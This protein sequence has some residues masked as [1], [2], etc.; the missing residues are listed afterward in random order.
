MTTRRFSIKADEYEV[1]RFSIPRRMDV[2][3]RLLAASPVNLVL[4]DA[5]DKKKYEDNARQT[6]EYE[7]SWGRRSDL[8]ASVKLDA[9]TWYLIIEGSTD[10]S[11]GILEIYLMD[12]V[13]SSS[14]VLL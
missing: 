12:D 5:E 7:A 3:I 4:L 14:R 6:H 1:F 2:H 9:G 13:R 11:N 8:E 10:D